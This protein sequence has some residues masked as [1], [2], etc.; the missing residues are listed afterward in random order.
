[1]SHRTAWTVFL[2][3]LLLALTATAAFAQS[4]GTKQVGIV[5]S[6]P[7]GSVHTEIVT[8]P[9]TATTLDVLHAAKLTI[10]TS[11][12]AYGTSLCKINATGCPADNCFCDAQHF[13]A[14]Y[15][16]NGTSWA[17]ASEAVSVYVPADRAVEGLTWSGFDANYNATDKP[18]V[19]T[20]D[21]LLAAQTQPVPVPE[22]GTVLLLGGG[23]AGLA[24]YARYLRGRALRR[25]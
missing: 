6:F 7:D 9:V 14:Y 4:G 16:L 1:M 15:H 12:S 22:P 19:Y 3:V 20:F 18:P 5:V 10:A 21:Q 2:V 23:I 13:W 17:T 24:G 8:V 25:A 11:E